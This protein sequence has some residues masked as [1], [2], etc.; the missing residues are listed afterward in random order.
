M[1]D[2]TGPIITD[3]EI[4]QFARMN[5]G[6]MPYLMT[7]FAKDSG[8]TPAE[9]AAFTGRTFAAGWEEMRGQ[10]AMAIV[11]IMAINLASCGGAAG[12]LSGDGQRAEARVSGVPS[13]EM[14]SFFGLSRDEVDQFLGSFGPI[15]THLGARSEWRRDGEEIVLT[16]GAP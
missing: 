10:G 3:D 8:R 6:A 11:R 15:A 13:E 2:A 12:S 14:A 4:N 7:A 16:V 5:A 1:T 9:V